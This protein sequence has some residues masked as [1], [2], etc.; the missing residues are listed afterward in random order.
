MYEY[1]VLEYS[2][3]GYETDVELFT[4]NLNETTLD[5]NEQKVKCETY[6]LI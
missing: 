1:T 4:S 6:F 3:T 5:K 2:I